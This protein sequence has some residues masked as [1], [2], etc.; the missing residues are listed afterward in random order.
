MSYAI[1][2][3]PVTDNVPIIPLDE[4]E[5][6]EYSMGNVEVWRDAIMLEGS[7]PDIQGDVIGVSA[8]T[9]LNGDITGYNVSRRK[10]VTIEAFRGGWVAQSALPPN[11][12]P[13]T[14]LIVITS[15]E[16]MINTLDARLQAIDDGYGRYGEIIPDATE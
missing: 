16:V 15:T 13:D 3:V 11:L 12:P 7:V 5:V 6:L 4:G 9:D 14:M 8:V 2:V 1:F 10:L